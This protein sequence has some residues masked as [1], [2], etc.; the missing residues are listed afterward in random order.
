MSLTLDSLRNNTRTIKLMFNGQPLTMEV[1]PDRLTSDSVDRYKDALE[2]RDYDE[3]AAV[4]ADVVQSWD[5]LES[6]GGDVL[7][8]NGDTFRSLPLRVLNGVW[9]E[10]VNAIAPKSRKKSGR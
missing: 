7:P 4:F 5:I 6:D 3:A 2:D 9:D 1:M 10:L 8:I